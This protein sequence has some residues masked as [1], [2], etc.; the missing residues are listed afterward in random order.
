MAQLTLNGM[1]AKV[2]DS[3]PIEYVCN[4]QINIVSIGQLIYCT[5]VG[6]LCVHGALI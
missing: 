3:K 6:I 2:M 4:L 1:K 5:K